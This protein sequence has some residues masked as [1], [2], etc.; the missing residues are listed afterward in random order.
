VSLGLREDATTAQVEQKIRD[1]INEGGKQRRKAE[2]AQRELN[3]VTTKRY[4]LEVTV[5]TLTRQKE[6]VEFELRNKDMTMKK[7]MRT[8]VYANTMQR[9]KDLL[10]NATGGSTRITTLPRIQSRSSSESLSLTPTGS[11]RQGH[12]KYC[13]F[14]RAD[15]DPVK[16]QKCRIHYRPIRSGKW[17]CCKDESHR[18]AGC[19]QIPHFYIEVAANNKVLLTDG[20]SYLEM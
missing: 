13:V 2:E 15:Y 1:T 17:T 5:K 10:D 3:K 20:I 11:A 9:T 8:R 19:L 4:E 7:M 12:R 18:S 16:V 6:H 14:C